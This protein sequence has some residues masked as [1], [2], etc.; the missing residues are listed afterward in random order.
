MGALELP[1][2]DGPRRYE[3]FV[4]ELA[5][6]LAQGYTGNITICVQR[7]LIRHYRTEKV[8]VPGEE[9]VGLRAVG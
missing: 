9:D 5:T 1:P 2:R 8:Q 4:R 7:G 3:A 6:L